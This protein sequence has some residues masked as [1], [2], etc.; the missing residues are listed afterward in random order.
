MIGVSIASVRLL[1]GTQICREGRIASHHRE[2]LEIVAGLGCQLERNRRP[3]L[4]LGDDIHAAA[5]NC[6]HIAVV[7]YAVH[8]DNLIELHLLRRLLQLEGDVFGDG[9]RILDIVIAAAGAVGNAPGKII[10]VLRQLRESDLLACL[11]QLQIDQPVVRDEFDGV[12]IF[13]HQCGEGRVLGDNRLVAGLVEAALAVLPDDKAVAVI[14]IRRRQGD[15]FAALDLGCVD[16][17]AVGHSYQ[18]PCRPHRPG[19]GPGPRPAPRAS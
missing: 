12:F 11:D 8:I 9:V 1:E 10:A 13:A 2:G 14:Q 18:A 5:K 6:R 15:A 3:R 7:F 16:R 17:R 4:C 19:T